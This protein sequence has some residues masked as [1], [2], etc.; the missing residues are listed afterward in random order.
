MIDC[1]VVIKI[2][3]GAIYHRDSETLFFYNKKDNHIQG[4][5]HKLTT[6]ENLFKLLKD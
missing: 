5:D 6:G 4:E 2:G 3:K 1:L